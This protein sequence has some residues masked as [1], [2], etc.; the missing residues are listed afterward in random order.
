MTAQEGLSSWKGSCS[1]RPA[2]LRASHFYRAKGKAIP[3]LVSSRQIAP[4]RA[5]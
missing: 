1:S 3:V 2:K 4:A 5:T